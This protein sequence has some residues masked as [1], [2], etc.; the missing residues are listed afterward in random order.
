MREL[1]VIHEHSLLVQEY[2]ICAPIMF[3]GDSQTKILTEEISEKKTLLSFFF[4]HC[5]LQERSNAYTSIENFIFAEASASVRLM[6]T[7]APCLFTFNSRAR[8]FTTCS[9]FLMISD[10]VFSIPLGR[11]ICACS[12]LRLYSI[13]ATCHITIRPETPARKLTI[14]AY[15]HLFNECSVYS[16]VI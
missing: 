5:L 10:T 6:L 8:S 2:G 11:G 16:T 9:G 3:Q 12:C 15:K 1:P 7:T 14:S 13:P 4:M